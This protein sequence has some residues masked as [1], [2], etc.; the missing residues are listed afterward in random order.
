MAYASPGATAI[1][2]RLAAMPCRTRLG[3]S[4]CSTRDRRASARSLWVVVQRGE[5][6]A[7]EPSVASALADEWGAM[8]RRRAANPWLPLV[9]MIFEGAVP[10]FRDERWWLHTGDSVLPMRLSDEAG[11][12]LGAYSGGHP[13][14]VF[15][16]WD[17]DQAA[18]LTA[19]GSEG[20][21]L[22][23]SAP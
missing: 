5:T 14:A 12:Q 6:R 1:G 17:G 21:W 22:N 4:S 15:C 23:G 11:W 2:W 10:A 13:V 8:A 7:G 3:D 19:W 9:P 18:P 16:E 20:L